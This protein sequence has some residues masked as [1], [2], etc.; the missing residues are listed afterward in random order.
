M[1]LREC[2]QRLD[3]AESAAQRC[4]RPA[5]GDGAVPTALQ[6]AAGHQLT[7]HGVGGGTADRGFPD[8]LGHGETPA[9]LEPVGLVLDG[10]GV[11]ERRQLGTHGTTENWN[12]FTRRTLTTA[13]S[14]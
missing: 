12:V 6:P 2:G 10:L 8:Q 14:R 1:R 9:R 11:G 4:E 13:Q 5:N 7:H 3:G